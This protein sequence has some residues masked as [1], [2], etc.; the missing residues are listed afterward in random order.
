MYKSIVSIFVRHLTIS[1][2]LI[3]GED[4]DQSVSFRRSLTTMTPSAETYPHVPFRRLDKA[5]EELKGTSAG[6]AQSG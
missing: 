4:Y 1:I 5:S 2:K 3:S 6:D